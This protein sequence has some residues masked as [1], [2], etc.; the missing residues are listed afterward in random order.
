MGHLIST[1]NTQK[2]TYTFSNSDFKQ[3]FAL[4]SKIL[5]RE[6]LQVTAKHGMKA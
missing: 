5:A 3:V 4:N 1:I 2:Y 6:V